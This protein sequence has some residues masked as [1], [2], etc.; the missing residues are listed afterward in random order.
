MSAGF[1]QECIFRDPD[2]NFASHF[3]SIWMPRPPKRELRSTCGV[4]K[5]QIVIP[6]HGH[7]FQTTVKSGGGELYR[8]SS[9]PLGTEKGNTFWQLPGR[10]EA[11]LTGF[12]AMPGE[13]K[14]C[15]GPRPEPSIYSLEPTG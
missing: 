7:K 1:N 11:L 13:G 9:P 12:L 14:F 3:G 8:K 6:Q 4:P 15:W 10:R 2:L 5:E